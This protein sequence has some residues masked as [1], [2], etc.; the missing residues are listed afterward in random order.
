MPKI[1]VIIAVYKAERYIER[2]CHSLFG[3]SLEDIEY[4]F[5]DDCSPDNSIAVMRKVLD[6]YPNR[7]KQVKI[8][9]HESNC[10]VSKTRQD[11]IDVSTGEFIIHCDPDDWVELDAYESALNEALRHC[12]DFVIFDDF[13]AKKWPSSNVSNYTN[14][15]LLQDLTGF[16]GT[17]SFPGMWRNLIRANVAKSVRMPDDVSN[18]E[19]ANY[20]FQILKNDIRIVYL[21]RRLYHYCDNP[22]SVTKQRTKSDLTKDNNNIRLIEAMKTGYNEAYDHC[23]D[24]FIFCIIY[25]RIYPSALYSNSEFRKQFKKFLYTAKYYRRGGFV[26][27]LLVKISMLGLYHQM[28]WI[29][30]I[31]GRIRRNSKL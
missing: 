10:G 19:D 20:I 16:S 14:I 28:L 22:H 25:T 30:N 6:K 17:Y 24:A 23:L 29:G 27:R 26:S 15:S 3:Q 13:R 8:I 4:I 1:S 9:R 21:N 11:G 5:V 31:I 7:A 18:G 2:C 12:A